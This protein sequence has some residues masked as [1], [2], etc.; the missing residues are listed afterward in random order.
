MTARSGNLPPHRARGRLGLSH[1]RPRR[2]RPRRADP[3]CRC[4]HRRAFAGAGSPGQDRRDHS[5]QTRTAPPRAGRRR[6]RRRPARPPPRSRVAAE[7]GRDQPHPRRGRDRPTRRPDRRPEEAGAPGHSL[8]R[9][10][11]QGAQGRGHAV[12]SA[13]AG[14]Q[15]RRRGSRRTPTTSTFARWPSAPASRPR[16]RASRRSAPPN[17][18]RCARAK[19]APRPG[20]S[21][22]P[23]R[24]NSSTAR[25]SAPRS[26]SPSS[27]GG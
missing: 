18:R 26:A 22:S 1:Q 25:K 9:S 21:A 2:A 10:R 20:C 15:C 8:P 24:A 17:C 19:P 6:R 7:G 27:T 16:P 12:P 14:S 23:M 5:G 13:L 11:R 3:V 4:R